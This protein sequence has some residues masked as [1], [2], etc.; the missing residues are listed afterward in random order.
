[1]ILRLLTLSVLTLFASCKPP[2]KEAARYDLDYAFS[3][4]NKTENKHCKPNEKSLVEI[5]KAAPDV[6]VTFEVR[7]L[8]QERPFVAE[9]CEVYN[10][11]DKRSETS[12]K[13]D[14][15]LVAKTDSPNAYTSKVTFAKPLE[16]GSYIL[17]ISF[18]SGGRVFMYWPD[19][20]VN[21]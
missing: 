19:L 21:P 20:K 6:F 4:C 10:V 16:V 12:C 7:R 2:F 18:E 11:K 13:I 5:S 1:M 8:D 15:M 17:K 9:R 3:A 14:S